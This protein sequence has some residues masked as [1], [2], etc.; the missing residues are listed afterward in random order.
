MSTSLSAGPEPIRSHR[1]E[2]RAEGEKSQ[3][4]QDWAPIR[5][6]DFYDVPRAFVADFGD[7]TLFFDCAFDDALDDYPSVYTVYRVDAASRERFDRDSWEGVERGLQRLGEVPVDPQMFDPTRRKA[8]RGETPTL[9]RA[10]SLRRA[11]RG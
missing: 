7:E 11:A 5:Y 10:S 3:V 8:V 1:A 6:R 4:M 9:L 2:P